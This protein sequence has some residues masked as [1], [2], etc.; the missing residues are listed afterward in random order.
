MRFE[1]AVHL[2]G[3]SGKSC[4]VLMGFRVLPF[5]ARNPMTEIT[6]FIRQSELVRRPH[7][8]AMKHGRAI[9]L[10]SFGSRPEK[11]GKGAGHL[12][13]AALSSTIWK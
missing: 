2:E 4:D 12:H 3:C 11:L 13:P 1:M 5:Q 7:C 9:L 6:G 8:D 10:R